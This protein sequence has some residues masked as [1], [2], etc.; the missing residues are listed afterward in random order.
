MLATLPKLLMTSGTF[1]PVYVIDLLTA[2]D[3]VSIS[4]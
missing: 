2:S 4:T 3:L 1:F